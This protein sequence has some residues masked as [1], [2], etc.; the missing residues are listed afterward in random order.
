MVQRENSLVGV[1]PLDTVSHDE[2]RQNEVETAL[3]IHSGFKAL[4]AF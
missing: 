3:I 2:H 1:S 4:N